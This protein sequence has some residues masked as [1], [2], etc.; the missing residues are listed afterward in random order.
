MARRLPLACVASRTN[1]CRDPTSQYLESE[2]ELIE[3][4]RRV[5]SA[6]CIS[7]FG[8]CGRSTEGVSSALQQRTVDCDYDYVATIDCISSD[9]PHPHAPES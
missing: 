9:S 8:G 1:D 3:Q 2:F 7:L 6:M 4:V 5:N